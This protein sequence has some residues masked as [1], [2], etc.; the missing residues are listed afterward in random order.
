[1]MRA[2]AKMLKGIFLS[3]WGGGKTTL[4]SVVVAL[5]LATATPAFGAN[6]KPLIMGVLTNQA[7]AV[8]RLTAN[9]ANP[10]L[11]IINTNASG[12]ALQLLTSTNRPPMIVNS[13]TKVP[14]LNADK[15]D[16]KDAPLWAVVRD[17]GSLDRSNGA[18]SSR[19]EG[20]GI[21][22]VSFNKP[23]QNCA[24]TATIGGD[25]NSATVPSDGIVK[26]M[27]SSNVN[28]VTVRVVNL[29]GFDTE[30]GFHLVVNC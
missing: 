17:D 15:V 13:A 1:M 21:Y 9:I 3:V 30:R 2:T 26:V 19:L 23:V 4:L 27:N 14:N 16:G 7:T 18:T 29:G 11:Q 10:A 8:T 20:V 24:Y 12:T 6:G 25:Y 22:T 28:D 5:T